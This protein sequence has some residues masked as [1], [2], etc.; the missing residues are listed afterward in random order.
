M[1]ILE[2][3]LKQNPD[4]LIRAPGFEVD[5]EGSL[6]LQKLLLKKI[7]NHALQ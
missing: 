6:L 1:V 7:S 2:K 5:N 4:L 3:L